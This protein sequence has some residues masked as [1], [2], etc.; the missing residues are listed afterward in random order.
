MTF[1]TLEKN[2][3]Y[4]VEDLKRTFKG[5]FTIMS[6]LKYSPEKL[7]DIYKGAKYFFPIM[8]TYDFNYFAV[9]GT[10]LGAV[11]HGGIIPWDY[12]I[13]VAI[14]KKTYFKIID[15]LDELNKINSEYY[16]ANVCAPGIRIFYQ[17]NALIDLFVVDFIDKTHLAYSGNY[18]KDKQPTFL[19]HYY[20]FPKIKPLQKKIYPLKWMDFEDLKIRVPNDPKYFLYLNYNK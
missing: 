1:K 7:N 10:L 4:F 16:W 18:T 11:R 8:N 12:D 5:E 17:D 9:G 2:Q 14:T 19:T 15:L 20:C 6:P 13:D 3:T